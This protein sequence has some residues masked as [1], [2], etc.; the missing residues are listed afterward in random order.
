MLSS[1]IRAGR[2][3]LIDVPKVDDMIQCNQFTSSKYV[4]FVLLI[5]QEL[6]AVVLRKSDRK[7]TDYVI[8]LYG[9]CIRP[10]QCTFPICVF[11]SAFNAV[12]RMDAASLYSFKMPGEKTFHVVFN[13]RKL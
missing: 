9:T 12:T 4:C 10:L 3:R 13:E 6:L 7:K 11:S 5:W 1:E 2:R 8:I